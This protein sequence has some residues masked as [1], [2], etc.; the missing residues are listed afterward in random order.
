[1]SEDAKTVLLF[2]VLMVLVSSVT[3][4]FMYDFYFK[5]CS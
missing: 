4:W 2:V 5:L 3:A 1:M